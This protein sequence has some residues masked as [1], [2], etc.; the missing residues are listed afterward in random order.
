[1]LSTT[2]R[3]R[4]N[5]AKHKART[6]RADLYDV[7]DHGLLCHL[8][9]VVDGTPL[10][11]PTCHARIG[12][13]LYLH[14]STGAR[15]LRQGSEVCVTVTVPDG[16]VLARSAV[17]HSFNHRSAMVLG[18][19]RVVEDGDERLD[20][21]R[22]IVDHL[23]PGRWDQVRAPSKQDL[24]KTRVL[25]LPLDEASVKVRTGGPNDEP[26]DALLPVWAGELP[27]TLTVGEPRQDPA[28]QVDVPLPEHVARL[29]GRTW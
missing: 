21:L 28:R 22:A 20:A 12:D 1:M 23:V 4:L 7:L 15:S 29:A 25:A 24:A 11:L 16:L 5:R 26:E 17:H 6:D 10:A 27:L 19:P 18:T 9:V 8:A 2:E 14:G 3:T 13:T